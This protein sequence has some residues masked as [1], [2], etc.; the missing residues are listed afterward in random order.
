VRQSSRDGGEEG[1]VK[2]S[3]AHPIVVQLHKAGRELGHRMIPSPVTSTLDRAV[4]LAA[5]SCGVLRRPPG[6]PIVIITGEAGGGVSTVVMM[7]AP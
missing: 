5:A 4:H 7:G 1:G 2:T 6:T 3:G